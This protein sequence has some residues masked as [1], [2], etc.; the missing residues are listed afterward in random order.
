MLDAALRS[1]AEQ[2]I[3][4]SFEVLVIDNG[5]HHAEVADYWS[6]WRSRYWHEAEPG[7][8]WPARGLAEAQGDILVCR[9]RHRGTT[10][11]ASNF[12]EVFDPDVAMAGG[13]NR[14]CSA[15]TAALARV[16]V[17]SYRNSRPLR[18]EYPRMAGGPIPDYPY[19]IATCHP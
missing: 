1:V 15:D 7:L 12:A 3:D 17:E 6:V 9:R 18:I 16:A 8:T 14:R 5:S 10:W 11:L 2:R 4:P 13:N 19:Q